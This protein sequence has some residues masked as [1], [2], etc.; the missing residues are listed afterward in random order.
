[1]SVTT[2][3]FCAFSIEIMCLIYH[4]GDTGNRPPMKKSLH[5]YNFF[6]L[7]EIRKIF[8]DYILSRQN[9]EHPTESIFIL[10]SIS[11]N[12]SEI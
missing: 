6:G 5:G 11:I 8:L 7:E 9:H 12:T 2:L 10:I 1:M 3:N 4:F